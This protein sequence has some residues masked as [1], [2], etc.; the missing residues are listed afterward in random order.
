MNKKDLELTV[1]LDGCRGFCGSIL[2]HQWFA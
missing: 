1:G 2:P